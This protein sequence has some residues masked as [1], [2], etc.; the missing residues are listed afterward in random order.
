MKKTSRKY[1]LFRLW[2]YLGRHKGM[3][4]AGLI[5]MILSNVL[6]LLGPRLSG[7]AIDAIGT[8]AGSVD[9]GRVFYYVCVMIAFYLLSAAFSYL[10]SLLTIR[11]TRN[12]IYRMRKDVFESLV[13][14]PISYFDRFQTG[15]IISVVSYDIDTVNQSLAGD[16]LQ[17]LQSVITVFFSLVM[18]LSIAPVMVLIFAVTIPVSILMTK[19]V[20]GRSRPL[21]RVRS[22]KLGELNGFVEEMLNGQ[23]TT[24][25]YGREKEVIETFE[26]KNVEA[27][28][29]NTRAEY[30]GTLS[31]PSV[32]F[33]NNISL[34]LISV[35]GS[36]LYLYGKIGLGDVS[37]FIQ[38][39][40]KFSG[41]INETA[42]II[43]ELQSTFAA[44]ERVFRLID[45]LPEKPDAEGAR[46]LQEVY[47][48]V[49][50]KSVS[51]SYQEGQPI[52]HDFDL[53]AKAG[54]Q[55]AIVGPTGAGK[56]TVINLLM[57]FYDIDAGT[58]LLDEQS[59]Y[60]ITRDS[61]RSAYSMV[62]QETWLFHGTV[63]ENL[64]YGNEAIT[65][66]KVV[67]A[68]KAAEI[69]SYIM[70]LPNG[71]DTLLS[72]NGVHISKGQRQLLTI[73][74]AMLSD[75]RMLILDEATSN[76]DTRTEVS[77]RK[78]MRKLMENKTCFIIAHRLSTIQNA[79]RILVVK[80]GTVVERGTHE[81]L[82]RRKGFYAK[83]Y[84]ASLT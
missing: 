65:M 67:E 17:I 78:A 28:D 21:Y 27:V 20:T 69:H 76:V 3:L 7:K 74:R 59:I 12:V 46:I 73:A 64:T 22:Q 8:K 77:I 24:K 54:E 55:I 51:F 26:Q 47:G 2:Q 25:A 68:A 71:Y 75:A 57:R 40:R 63:Y 70:S 15:D 5:C 66:E 49:L 16:F 4:L 83:L 32:N 56:T 53:E 13:K 29:S 33:M 38:Y 23:K 35:V 82:I 79:D 48:D 18:M 6:S 45:E 31:G 39:S 84:A 14:L 58:I 62:L 44:A 30:Y 37:S 10:L 43:G 11:L 36:F 50:L 72:D 1:L 9:F 34:A 61:L 81:E 80:D 60:E 19:Y 52:L 42:N 41:P